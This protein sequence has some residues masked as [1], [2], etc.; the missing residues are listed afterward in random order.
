MSFNG[1]SW[2]IIERVLSLF[3][4]VLLESLLLLYDV[5]N[6]GY[7]LRFIDCI[8]GENLGEN[9]IGKTEKLEQ[10]NPQFSG[11]P[12]APR[13]YIDMGRGAHALRAPVH[14]L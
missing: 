11:F 9:R 8:F 13:G 7:R 6:V 14:A 4:R 5:I 3:L 1:G 2:E 10:E 12:Q